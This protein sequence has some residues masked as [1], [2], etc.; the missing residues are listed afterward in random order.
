M[1]KDKLDDQLFP[2]IS[3]FKQFELSGTSSNDKNVSPVWDIIRDSWK[4]CKKRN[5][6]I[7]GVGGIGKT[8]TLF[9]I[10]NI[11]DDS[12]PPAI[13]VP[14][15]R[16]VDELGN[17]IGI[18]EYI[19]NLSKRHSQEILD[20]ADSGW[21]NGPKLLI[22][23]DGFNEVP[24]SKRRLILHTIN[25]WNDCSGAQL[26]AVSRPMDGIN[27]SVEL[28]DDPITINLETLNQE[29]VRTYLGEHA[30]SDESLL[31]SVL[32]RPLF[33][34]LYL[35]TMFLDGCSCDGYNLAPKKTENGGSLIWNYLQR[36]LL[37]NNT[38]FWVIQCAF[39]CELILPYI[40]YYMVCKHLFTIERKLAVTLI[41]EA[42]SSINFEKLPHHLAAIFD[43]YESRH[44]KYP[45]LKVIDWNT[46]VL[47]DVGLLKAS[48]KQYSFI[49]QIFRDALAGL[50]LVIQ[51][52]MVNETETLPEV[53]VRASNRYVMD[54]AA[55]MMIETDAEKLWGINRNLH[56]TNQFATYA[57]LELQRRR[58]N[59]DGSKLDFSGM[60]LRGFS[61]IRYLKDGT[62]GERDLNLFRKPELS[63]QTLMSENTFRSPGHTSWVNCIATSEDGLC[64]SGSNDRTLKIWDLHTGEYYQSL[65]GHTDSVKCVAIIAKEHLCVSGSNDNNLR[66][67]NI[68]TGNCILEMKGHTDK[69][70]CVAVTE[71][72]FCVSG[73]DD[74]TIRLWNLNTGECIRIIEG[75]TDRVNCIVQLE[76]ELFIS[77]SDDNT[78][79]VWNITTGNCVQVM[80]EHK[81]HIKCIITTKDK[82]CISGSADKKVIV[83]NPYTGKVLHKLVGHNGPVNCITVS[84]KGLYISGSDDCT[85]RVWDSCTGKCIQKIAGHKRAIKCITTAIDN[86][87]VSGSEDNTIKV[88]DLDIYKCIYTINGFT[89]RINC[90]AVTDNGLCISGSHDKT[91]RI[92]DRYTEKNLRSFEGHTGAVRCVAVYKNFLISGSDDKT[93]RVWDINTGSCLYTIEGHYKPV[94][95]ISIT[96][97]GLLLSGSDDMTLKLWDIQ[98]KDSVVTMRGHGNWIRCIVDIGDGLCISGSADNTL[99]LWDME[100]GRCLRIMKGHTDWVNSIAVTENKLI[101]SGS[102]DKTLRVW[103][104][105]TGKCVRILQGHTD[106]VMCVA[107]TREGLCISGSGDKT[108]RIWDLSTGRCLRILRGHTQLIRCIAII[109]DDLCISGSND[110]TLRIW[111]INT[112]ECLTVLYSMEVDVSKMNLSKTILPPVIAKALRQN[113][114]IVSNNACAV[115][116]KL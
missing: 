48:K 92:W 8:I 46:T 51:A 34:N 105:F 70:N 3:E 69:I 83:W 30:P 87:F 15:H 94:T 64:I 26:I 72:G 62:Q 4:N 59:F 89:N 115:I 45:D 47:S 14:M 103:N 67:W 53:W 97:S 74:Q 63:K 7:T 43:E 91:I 35:K 49:H 85:I 29:D 109:R 84:E 76:S 50:Y 86:L 61:L 80:K 93:I 79:R 65:E 40:A 100:N 82:L 36:E 6:V 17:C 116:S 42:L 19:E 9:S 106:W 102:G 98:H 56:P 55:D 21:E 71:N 2:K 13:Y 25:D 23:L 22:L 54:Y 24:S 68:H 114:A 111:D 60:D 107:V 28:T 104:P 90:I 58:S 52:E 38:E 31:W 39:T 16:L 81:G 112:G 88:W 32:V 27:L 12:I 101:V 75:H 5:I 11:I 18:S 73:S 96:Q 41:K 1:K 10:T 44:F 108:L 113:Q 66:L 77:G 95:C 78:L 110:G 57:M 99:R 37:R 33:L 20:L